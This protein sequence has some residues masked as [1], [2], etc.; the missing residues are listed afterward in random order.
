M[1]PIHKLLNE[2]RWDP[3]Y[4]GSRFTIGYDDH[5]RGMVRVPLERVTAL[6]G[7]HFMFEVLEED[8]RTSTVPLH[9]IREVL[10]DGVP[11]WQRRVERSAR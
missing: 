5:V 11:F 9:R 6:P 1:M 4:A 7:S 10:R 2:L 3:Q 8:G